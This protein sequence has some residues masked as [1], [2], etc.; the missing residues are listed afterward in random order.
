MEDRYN[1]I[2]DYLRKQHNANVSEVKGS[3]HGNGHLYH[4][5]D[6]INDNDNNSIRNRPTV[7]SNLIFFGKVMVFLAAVLL[8]S[9]YIYGGQNLKKGAEMAWRDANT[10]ITKL[11]NEND[12]VRETMG[13]VRT[14]WHKVKDFAGE[15]INA[16]ESIPETATDS[17]EQKPENVTGYDEQ[18]LETA[19]D[20]DEQK[21][22]NVTGSDEQIS[23]TATD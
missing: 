12:T 9:C 8:C 6:V 20:S 15:Y 4:Y 21:P 19:T 1:E 13:Y 22:E 18:I 10:G 7:W 5:D 23:D 11:E 14:A 16:E 2:R 17:D 3:Y